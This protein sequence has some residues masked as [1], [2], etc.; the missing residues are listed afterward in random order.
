MKVTTRKNEI[1]G[2]LTKYPEVVDK[3]EQLT[4]I[5]IEEERDFLE[6]AGINEIKFIQGRIQAYKK[7]RKLL[8]KP[9]TGLAE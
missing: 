1:I 7:L 8:A 6:T 3:I 9:V 2:S 4:D 5:L